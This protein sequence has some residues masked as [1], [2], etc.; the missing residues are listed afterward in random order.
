VRE[1]VP[2]GVFV[3]ASNLR[4]LQTKVNVTGHRIALNP[5]LNPAA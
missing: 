4:Y 5:A 2:T 1:K 3:T